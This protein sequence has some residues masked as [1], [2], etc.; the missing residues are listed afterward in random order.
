MVLVPLG[1]L[2][3]PASQ[4]DPCSPGAAKAAA[5]AAARLEG[6]EA[7]SEKSRREASECRAELVKARASA[8][9]AAAAVARSAGEAAHALEASEMCRAA[10]EELLRDLKRASGA[11]EDA[12]RLGSL[13][14][15]VCVHAMTC[16]CAQ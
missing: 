4:G 9:A 5:R 3:P 11:A 10:R 12:R 2:A 7:A 1:S 16:T 6:C 15:E 8:G 13:L 14:D